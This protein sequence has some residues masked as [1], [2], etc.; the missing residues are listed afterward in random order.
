M[1]GSEHSF[2]AYLSTYKNYPFKSFKIGDLDILFEG[3]MYDLSEAELEQQLSEI[4]ANKEDF[5]EPLAEW[6]AKRDGEFILAINDSKRKKLFV[7]NDFLGRLPLYYHQ[8]HGQFVVSRE[9]SVV[10]DSVQPE[11]DPVNQSVHLLFGFIVGYK[12]VHK[13][14]NKL[15]GHSMI[16][17]DLSKNEFATRSFSRIDSFLK[18]YDPTVTPER[19]KN[20]LSL[21]IKRRIDV[22]NPCG[23]AL[24]GGMDSRITAGLLSEAGIKLPSFTYIR[25]HIG[26]VQDIHSA[27]QIIERLGL[28]E[29]HEF[30]DLREIKPYQAEDLKRIKR[31]QNF[32]AMDF[33]IPF[34]EVFRDRGLCQITGDGGDMSIESI[35][36]LR[37]LWSENDMLNYLLKKDAI[38]PM[39]EVIAKT[40]LSESR[41]RKHVLQ[42]L[43]TDQSLSFDQRYAAF[44]LKG[45]GMEFS[46]EGEDR[47]RYYSWTATAYYA[48]ECLRLSLSIPVRNRKYGRLFTAIMELLPGRLEEI[49]NPNWALPPK[50]TGA[51][52]RLF[53]RQKVKTVIPDFLLK[54]IGK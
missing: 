23:L 12:T 34:L 41:I 39:K 40:G 48:P 28:E 44:I 13:G 19:L 53:F 54:L 30:V 3:Y 21:A 32:L 4:T 5:T 33:L 27:K 15:P 9:I 24:S 26:N 37:K 35:F 29:V 2:D 22:C 43:N 8:D 17:I 52:K 11:L 20:E 16:R 25:S 18:N 14:V 51:I 50:E 1:D 45:R 47:N 42:I 7:F 38:V 10:L 31:G 6:I 46:F 36:P 49:V